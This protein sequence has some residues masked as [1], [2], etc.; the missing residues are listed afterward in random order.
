MSYDD[1]IVASLRR[2]VAPVVL[3]DDCI[4][5]ARQFASDAAA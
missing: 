3:F 5:V 1:V 4:Y 2:S